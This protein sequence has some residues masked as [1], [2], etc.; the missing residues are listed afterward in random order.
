MINNNSPLENNE[1]NSDTNLPLNEANESNTGSKFRD[2]GK[3]SLAPLIDL[4]SKYKGD[5]N[6]YFAAIGKG[7]SGAVSA[8]EGNSATSTEMNSEGMAGMSGVSGSSA[9]GSEADRVVAGWFRDASNWFTGAQSKI[10]SGNGREL[11][12]YI[13]AEAAKRPGLMF[14]T[15]YVVGLFFGRLGRHLGRSR[16]SAGMTTASTGDTGFNSDASVNDLH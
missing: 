15:S 2:Y 5:I 9:S 12:S 4:V 6:P 14:S 7:L 3:K 8:L 1:S 16:T 11:L 10:E 13:E